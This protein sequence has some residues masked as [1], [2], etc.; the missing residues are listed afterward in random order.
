MDVELS[1]LPLV[2]LIQQINNNITLIQNQE[3]ALIQPTKDLIKDAAAQLKLIN[4]SKVQKQK[5]VHDFD[6]VLKR[7]AAASKLAAMASK[8]K[9]VSAKAHQSLL[10]ADEE[11]TEQEPLLSRTEQSFQLIQTFKFAVTRC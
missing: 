4:T 9:V 10:L 7:F 6:L 3:Y 8:Q 11:A 2:S 1:N 5:L